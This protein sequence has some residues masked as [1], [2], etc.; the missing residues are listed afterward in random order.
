LG[1]V[2][3]LSERFALSLCL[4]AA[5]IATLWLRA[6][7]AFHRARLWFPVG[8]DR[9]SRDQVKRM[10]RWAEDPEHLERMRNAP[11]TYPKNK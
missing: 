1:E 3:E 6:W 10:R 8:W 4:E 7:A 2:S 11:F 9:Y 5:M